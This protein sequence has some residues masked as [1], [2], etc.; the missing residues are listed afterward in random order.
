MGSAWSGLR[1]R[2]RT[3]LFAAAMAFV[4]VPNHARA[5]PLPERTVGLSFRDRAVLVSVGLQDL[6]SPAAR[7]RL[8]SGFATRVLVRIQLSRQNAQEPIAIAFQRI[9]IVYDIWDERFRVR[10]THGAG[11]DRAFEVKTLDEAFNAVATLINFPIELTEPLTPGERYVL[12]FRG[13]LNPLSPE[14]MGEVR[15]WLRQPA[16]AQPRPGAGRGDSFFGTFVTVF[17]NP[18][19]EDSERQ[20]RFLSQPFEGPR[21]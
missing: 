5:E 18:Q 2:A 16:G 14:L 10:T 9:E 19:I 12:A 17:V 13:D 6:F 21:R 7:D 3:L 1:G 15:R 8:T 20:L 11:S 4:L